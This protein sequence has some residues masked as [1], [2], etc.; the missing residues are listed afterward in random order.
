[1][2][3]RLS[4]IHFYK[5]YTTFVGSKPQPKKHSPNRSIPTLKTKDTHIRLIFGLKL[6]QLRKERGYSTA[7]LAGKLGL[8]MSYLNEIENGK[9]YPKT[10]KIMSIS[11]ALDV[12]YDRMVSLKLTKNLAPIGQI[13]ESNLL[14]DIPLELFG[15]DSQKLIE[16]IADAPMKVSAFISTIIE[17]GR[18]YGMTQENFYFAAL[19]SY[20]ELNENYFEDLEKQV[21]LFRNEF[22]MH[23]QS[24]DAKTL[25]DLLETQY[26]YDIDQETLGKHPQLNNI[27]SYFIPKKRKLLINKHLADTQKAFLFGKEIGYQYMK[28]G[29]EREYIT[30]WYKPSS[31]EQVLGNL[32]QSYFSGALMINETD[33]VADLEHFFSQ[34][35]WNGSLLNELMHKYNSSPEMFMQRL[36]NLVPKHFGLNNLFFLR[37]NKDFERNNDETHLTKELHIGQL[38]NPHAT[39]LNEHYCRRWISTSIFEHIKQLSDAGQYTQPIVAAQKSR[40]IDTKK[41]YFCITFA[42][43]MG[44]NPNQSLSVTIGILINN[45]SKKKI[46]FIDDPQVPTRDVNQACERCSIADC[47]Q[48]AAPAKSVEEARN[49]EYIEN[50]L[51]NLE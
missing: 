12:P 35:Q 26:G 30:P 16:I 15:I 39:E 13:L 19:R 24:F 20:Q 31:F 48:R 45:D 38:H 21:A 43:K 18:L 6:R 37:F 34:N 2:A 1:M 33:L 8:S 47:A 42:R 40:H 44:R 46:K 25:Q 29:D 4:K 32:K 50:T 28:L 14:D 27:R 23:N 9:K 7:E 5:Y 36:T 51:K 17:I 41:D 3:N 22:K 49:H 10:D 11:Q